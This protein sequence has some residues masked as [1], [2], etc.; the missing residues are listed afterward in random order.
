MNGYLC[1]NGHH[2]DRFKVVGYD[3]QT[4]WE[5]QVCP[6]CGSENFEEAFH[7]IKCDKY[8]VDDD[9]IGSICVEC[10][11]KRATKKNAYA[12]AMRCGD[13][14][15]TIDGMTDQEVRVYCFED[16]YDFSEFLE[17]EDD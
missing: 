1:A 9:M 5:D 17:G 10:V 13:D 2:F 12:Y 7:C 16:K 15:A 8:Y 11:K 6:V 4:G 14:P 3:A